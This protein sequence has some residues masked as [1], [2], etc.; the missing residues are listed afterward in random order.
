MLSV[1]RIR[2]SNPLKAFKTG[3]EIYAMILREFM[4]CCTVLLNSDRP[5]LIGQWFD[6]IFNE[7]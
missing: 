3:S 2:G 4:E 5:S 1:E 7:R 6:F